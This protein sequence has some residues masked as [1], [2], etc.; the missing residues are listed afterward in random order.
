VAPWLSWKDT[1][2]SEPTLVSAQVM[3]VSFVYG[4]VRVSVNTS[5]KAYEERD[6][7]SGGAGHVDAVRYTSQGV[8]RGS[9]GAS[10]EA[11]PA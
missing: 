3:M 11:E 4:G 10:L 7:S 2:M 9:W 5:K 1:A 8:R 6:P